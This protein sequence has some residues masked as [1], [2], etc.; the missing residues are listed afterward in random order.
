MKTRL[1]G[2][3]KVSQDGETRNLVFTFWLNDRVRSVSSFRALTSGFSIQAQAALSL[4]STSPSHSLT[5][6]HCT[7]SYAF[8]AQFSSSPL[9]WEVIILFLS[10]KLEVRYSKRLYR[11]KW[12]HALQFKDS[13]HIQFS[14]A[15]HWESIVYS[16]RV[17]I[18]GDT[19][20]TCA[21]AS[22]SL[23]VIQST[24]L[25]ASCLLHYK[26]KPA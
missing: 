9:F 17:A 26:V 20:C 2:L 19:S 16:P 24:K 23:H 1:H 14:L 13:N 6:P 18:F 5:L 3:N 7:A 8:S 12:S 10:T 11:R 15:S 25:M 22:R 4:L 21:R